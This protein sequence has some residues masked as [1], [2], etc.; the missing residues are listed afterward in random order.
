LPDG[1]FT[2]QKYQ[3]EYILEG[4]GIDDV[5]VSYDHVV[6]AMAFW[7]ILW[8]FGIFCGPFGTFYGHLV[9]FVGLW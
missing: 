9:Y 4:L 1:I 2:Y 8:S 7:Y 5:G 6:N 3:F